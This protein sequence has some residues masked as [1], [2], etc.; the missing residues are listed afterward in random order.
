MKIKQISIFLENTAGRIADV[1]R[2]LKNGEVNLRA[3]MIADTADFGILRIITDDSDKALNVLKEAK[4]TTR[5]T[6]VLAVSIKD[7]VGA[8][9]DVLSLFEKNS[10]NIEYLYASLEKTGDRAV[11]I[12]KVEDAERGMKL[13]EDNGLNTIDTF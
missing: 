10:V 2:I 9:H 3:I 12:F 13:I 11:I 1:T 5:T 4:F 8:L 7:S 6:D